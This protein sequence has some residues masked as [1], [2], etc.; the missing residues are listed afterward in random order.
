VEHA[1]KLLEK[2]ENVGVVEFEE[3]GHWPQLERPEAFALALARFLGD[4]LAARA[5]FRGAPL[6][7]RLPLWKRLF[8]ALRRRLGLLVEKLAVWLRRKRLPPP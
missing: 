6:E 2:M 3:C 8:Q 7:P 5:S 1:R 4:P